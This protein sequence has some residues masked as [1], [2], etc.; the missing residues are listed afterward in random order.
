MYPPRRA[1]LDPKQKYM[2][3]RYQRGAYADPHQNP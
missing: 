3:D 1:A 2:T